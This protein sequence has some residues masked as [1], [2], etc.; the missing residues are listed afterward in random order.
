MK[1]LVV[2]DDEVIADMLA[3]MLAIENY[4]VEVADDGEAAW[5]LIMVYEYDLLLI[6]I[7]LPRLDGISLCRRIRE[8]GN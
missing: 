8:H 3:C 6:D 2:E 4:T 7:T 5:E 1:I